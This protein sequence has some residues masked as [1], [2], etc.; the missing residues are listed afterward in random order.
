M[1]IQYVVIQHPVDEYIDGYFNERSIIGVFFAE[2]YLNLYMLLNEI[3]IPSGIAFAE[4]P[5]GSGFIF[6]QEQIQFQSEFHSEKV[7]FEQVAFES[8]AILN[9]ALQ[10]GLPWK[11]F[12]ESTG[13][14]HWE[15]VAEP[16]LLN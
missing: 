15:Y 12:T 9:K 11:V 14:I 3:L 5:E 13:I 4:V 10:E 8:T 2:N 1:G 16:Q 7:E 6:T